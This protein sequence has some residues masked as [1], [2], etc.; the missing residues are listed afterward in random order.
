MKAKE[1]ATLLTNTQDR[2][3]TLKAFF[4]EFITTA[5]SKVRDPF[6][7]INI[8]DN[9][10]KEQEQKFRAVCRLVP[11]LA[12]TMWPSLVKQYVARNIV[13]EIEFYR[14]NQRARVRRAA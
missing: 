8:Y 4:E 11:T 2:D 6:K 9:A 3:Y 12:P 10:F 14:D 5:R 7:S 13:A 1:W